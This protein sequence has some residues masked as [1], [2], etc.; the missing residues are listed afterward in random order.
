MTIKKLARVIKYLRSTPDIGLTLEAEWTQIVKWWVDAS[1][2]VHPDMRSHTGG[3]MSMGK[4]TAYGTSTRQRLNTKS[5]TEA[6]L[7]GV[8][9][10]LP[11]I[12]WIR[13]FL[14]EQGYTATESIVYQD[15]QSAILL[16][17]NG[18]ASSSKWTRH[19]KIRYF[20]VTDPFNSGGWSIAQPQI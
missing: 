6:E 1:Y 14:Q 4:G 8:N 5:S 2:A 10:V 9:E 12:L 20:F 18:K 15:N 19:I 7:V 17:K 3:A 11:Q 16:E 13:Y